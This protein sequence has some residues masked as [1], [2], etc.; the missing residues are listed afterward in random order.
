M[1]PQRPQTD[2]DLPLDI[3]YADAVDFVSHSRAF[4]N[5]VESIAPTCLRRWFLFVDESK[6]E[7]I[8]MRR[9]TDRVAEVWRVTKKLGSVLGDAEDMARRKQ[10]ALLAFRRMWTLWL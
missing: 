6:T 7:R 2:I 3:A 9:E 10:L 8:S 4:L 5:Q 1:L